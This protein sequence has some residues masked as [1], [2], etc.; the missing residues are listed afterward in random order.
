MCIKK[1]KKEVLAFSS[2]D[3]GGLERC[4]WLGGGGWG[5]RLWRDSGQCSLASCH[6]GFGAVVGGEN[7]V[8][9]NRS[10]W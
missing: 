4:W 9:L 7:G 5:R 8:R 1:T 3:D 10:K 2:S 6:Q